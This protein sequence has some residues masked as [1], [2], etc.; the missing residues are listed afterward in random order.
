MTRLLVSAVFLKIRGTST[1][2]KKHVERASPRSV[3]KKHDQHVLQWGRTVFESQ[4]QERDKILS[5]RIGNAKRRNRESVRKEN[6][7][8]TSTTSDTRPSTDLGHVTAELHAR[9]WVPILPTHLPFSTPPPCAL[10]GIGL[11]A[12][13]VE[14]FPK[15]PAP[16]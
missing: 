16:H 2:P 6:S 10:S 13:W 8:S 7:L 5:N 1:S 3:E 11:S 4:R 15:Q 9:R 14:M 12:G